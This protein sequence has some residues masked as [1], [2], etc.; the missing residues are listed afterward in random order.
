MEEKKQL[1]N[2]IGIGLLLFLTIIITAALFNIIIE[3]VLFY[4]KLN[5][6]LIFWLKEFTEIVIFI[7]LTFISYK[8]IKGKELIE[9]INFKQI[10]R[11]LIV[12]LLISSLLQFLVPFVISGN[13]LSVI[14]SEQMKYYSNIQFSYLYPILS[15]IFTY[16]KYAISIKIFI[17]LS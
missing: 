4:C 3:K 15:A 1:L 14:S 11:T 8:Y 5:S 7:S 9:N 6:Y 16:L 10:F 13:L 12:I 17:K 2:Y